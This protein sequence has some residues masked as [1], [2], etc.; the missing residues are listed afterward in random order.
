MSEICYLISICDRSKM[1][2]FIDLF[3]ADGLS[4]VFVSLGYGTAGNEISD[5]LGLTDTEKAVLTSFATRETWIRIKNDLHSSLRIH[6]PGSGIAFLVPAGSVAGKQQLKFLLSNQEFVLEE[7][8]SMKDTRYEMIMI[9]ANVGYS[10]QIMNVARRE[11]AGGGT[12]IHA[13]GTG[14]EGG[15]KFLGF[16]L[17]SEK[18]II[19]IVTRTD[20]R[21]AIMSAVNRECGKNSEAKAICFSLPVSST[22]GVSFAEADGGDGT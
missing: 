12:I 3:R 22:A 9:I 18:E 15:E 7:E 1:R 10:D 11:G 14:V 16:T 20:G 8:S 2:E 19:M 6:D 13:R 17:A 5:K 21:N 4:P